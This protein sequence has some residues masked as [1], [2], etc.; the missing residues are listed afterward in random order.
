M[1]S[2]GTF[3]I[4]TKTSLI[5]LGLTTFNASSKSFLVTLIF[6][7]T[8]LRIDSCLFKFK[9]GNILLRTTIAASFAKE[10]KSAPTNP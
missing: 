9:S 10:D 1:D 2:H 8:F 6:S 7:N 5:A 3:G 4:S